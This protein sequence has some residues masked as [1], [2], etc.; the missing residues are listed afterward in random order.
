MRCVPIYLQILFSF[1][2]VIIPRYTYASI[3]DIALQDMPAEDNFIRVGLDYE[4]SDNIYKVSQNK[5]SNQRVNAD[6][7]F[8]YQR[9]RQYNNLSLNYEAQ[10]KDESYNSD[11]DSNYWLGKGAFTQQL[12]SK[13]LVFGISHQRQRFI[14]N[15]QQADSDSNQTERDIFIVEQYWHIPYSKRARFS[16][17]VQHSDAQFKDFT[18]KDSIQNSA[19]ISWEQKLNKISQLQFTY[20][21]SENEFNLN[22]QYYYEQNISAQYSGQYRLGEYLFELGKSH[23][24][25]EQ[26]KGGGLDY[27]ILIN[28][29]IKAHLFSLE[30]ERTLSN[31]SF[32]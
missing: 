20:R 19:D 6:V 32:R 12:F 23:V 9:K 22:T 31:S 7:A 27:H 15:Q 8:N 13:N 24:K 2:L 28:T 10:Y 26:K 11:E 1:L 17:H 18:D 30:T 25:K 5:E 3:E 14:I 16:L 4:H 29:R 21:Y